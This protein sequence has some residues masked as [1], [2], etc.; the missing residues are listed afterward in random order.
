MQ[1]F[2]TSDLLA[3]DGNT[4]LVTA[5]SSSNPINLSL[6]SFTGDGGSDQ[7]YVSINTVRINA[8][9]LDN[10][11]STCPVFCGHVPAM[12]D[13]ARRHPDVGWLVIHT[14]EAHPAK[15]RRSITASRTSAPLPAGWRQ[16]RPS[17]GGCSSTT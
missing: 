17:R 4:T 1:G 13:L 5:V 14:R 12:E 3:T 7:S 10:I 6:N 11:N 9:A 8:T 15:R 2:N 16:R